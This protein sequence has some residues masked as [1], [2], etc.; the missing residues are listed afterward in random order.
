MERARRRYQKL[1]IIFFVFSI[2][3]GKYSCTETEKS[4]TD[5]D[6]VN[7]VV[8]QVNVGVILDMESTEGKIV[9]SCISMAISDFY[10]LH[11]NYTTKLV[12]NTRDSERQPLLALSS[13]LDLLN[14]EKVEAI[15]GGQTTME[16][17]FL[18]ELGDKAEVPVISLAGSN[19]LSLF[20]KH[21][22]FIQITHE[23]E[24]SQFNGI[25]A[26]VEAF[27]WKEVVLLYEDTD[28]VVSAIIESFQEHNIHIAYKCAIAASEH[29]EEVIY[30][31]LRTLMKLQSTV[32][33]VHMSRILAAQLLVDARKLG[34]MK[35]GY[36]W[37]MTSNTMNN[38]L[39]LVD[40]YVME[41]MQGVIGF[42]S[43]IPTS[44]ALLNVTSTLRR[45]FYME[46]PSVEIIESSPHCVWAY[47][48]TRAL[49]EAVER[50][51]LRSSK[52]GSTLLL[53]E[54]L[55]SR[56]MGLSGKFEFQNGKL[57]PNGFEIVNVI[58]KSWRRVG[59][60]NDHEKESKEEPKGRHLLSPND[61]EAIIWPGGSTKIP[62]AARSLLSGTKLRVGVP[63]MKNGFTELVQ[64]HH[65][66]QSNAT[67]AS[68]FCVEVFK[69]AINLLPYQVQYEFLPANSYADLID[70]VYHQ[71][72]DAAVGDIT[73]T[74]NR[75]LYVD[76]TL[77][78]TDLG[79]GM[80]VRHD[81]KNM[82]IFLKPLSADLWITTTVFFIFTGV[83]VWVIERPSNEDF[84]GSPSDQIGTIL[85][86]SFSTLVFAHR[87]KLIS[88][89][90][91]FVVIV[92]V[93]VVLILTSSY[94]ATLTSMMTVHQIQL[95]EKG[96]YI[97]YQMGS[98]T[99]GA[100]SNVNYKGFKPVHSPDEYADA[101]SRGSK[102]GGVSVIIDEIPYIKIF[103]AR[104]P[105]HYSMIK[106]ISSS[107]GFGFAF[108]KGSPLAND[109]SRAI[110]KL[111]EE[112]ELAKLEKIWLHNTKTSLTSLDSANGGESID[113]LNLHRF[114]GLFLVSGASSALAL[115]LFLVFAFRRR[116]MSKRILL[117]E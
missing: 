54:M 105:N 63:V 96:N 84:Q 98:F 93:F 18:A 26:I 51:K 50:A 102:H 65:N 99:L 92:W 32:F 76:F 80:V 100:L 34:M 12:L 21:P 66:P 55:E 106:T 24:I 39:H 73:I 77:S 3:L 41:S 46:N 48:S 8:N 42:K 11:T 67:N 113:A 4:Q 85:W 61:F 117:P 81:N 45:K 14:N 30:K 103:L 37:F 88:N 1:I 16:A 20:R 72:Y 71:H 9:H 69:A 104:Y 68:G 107:N 33:I 97:G 89:L 5:H 2:F 31:E 57:I 53:Q 56:F 75:S 60:W 110:A 83:V 7:D 74:S 79:V 95:N 27:K 62:K 109:M 35:E 6:H 36:A 78:Y 112:G 49:A 116:C 29:D 59:F 28:D 115:L 58:G 86:F 90:S 87:E 23:H 25:A 101:L 64:L 43:Y 44:K 15:I 38:L 47:D 108:R 19:S 17:K 70:Q 40:L 114:G 10:T 52:H 22:F 91:K 82:W 94:T 13:A 111:R